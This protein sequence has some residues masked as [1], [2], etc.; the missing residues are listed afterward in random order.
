M[1]DYNIYEIPVKMKLLYFLFAASVLFGIAFLFYRNFVL[2]GLVCPAGLLYLKAKKKSIITKRRNELN[3]QFKD[4]L[5][6]L[7]SSLG[8][9]KALE[10]AFENAL[11]DLQVLYPGEDIYIIRETK[12]IINKLALNVT[13]EEAISDLADRSGLDDIRNFSDV[14]C[15]CKRSGGNLIE[16]IKNSAGIIADKIEMKQ[17]I[18][19]ILS[20]RK[21]EQRIL[22][23]MPL[24]MIFIL[25]TTASEYISPIFT[26]TVG[27]ISMT[28]C[29]LMLVAAFILSNKI[30][31]IKM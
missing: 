7:V 18:E 16:A 20:S 1:I 28:V 19:T 12:I 25:S 13:M 6:S 17:E 15:I 2:A 26:S 27:R 9:G 22:N 5:V 24:G 14:I 10:N 29:L 23:I 31:N 8:A 11:S 30:M 3:L 21:F 4:L